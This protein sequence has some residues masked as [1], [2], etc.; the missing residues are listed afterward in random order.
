MLQ[1]QSK[2]FDIVRNLQVGDVVLVCED[3]VPRSQ[4]PMGVV[5]ETHQGSDGLVRS[6]KIRSGQS[7]K[8][9]P[10]IKL[11]LLEQCSKLEL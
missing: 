9:R 10:I 8:V 2:W 7:Y 6:A 1:E 5:E 3:Y 4:W 11:C